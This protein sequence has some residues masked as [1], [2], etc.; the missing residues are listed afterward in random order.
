MQLNCP[1][2]DEHGWAAAFVDEK[3]VKVDRDIVDC[4]WL[5]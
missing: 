1:W 4:V 3:L 5:D 2:D